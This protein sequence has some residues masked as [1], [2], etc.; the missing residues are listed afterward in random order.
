MQRKRRA[1]EIQEIC[2]WIVLECAIVG[3]VACIE[4]TAY[5]LGTWIVLFAIGSLLCLVGLTVSSPQELDRQAFKRSLKLESFSPS[6][7][8][9]RLNGHFFKPY[10]QEIPGAGKQ[11]RLSST[12]P[13]SEDVEAALIRYLINEGLSETLWP[14]MSKR[15]ELE[16][17][18]AF[19]A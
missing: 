9:F 11:F 7:K 4:Y 8:A 13:L 15:I 6:L 10:E 2:V 14:E 19:P 18:W 17:A 1:Y 3:T 12:K 16:S 5:H